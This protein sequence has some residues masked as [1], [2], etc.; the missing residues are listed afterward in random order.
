MNPLVPAALMVT[1]CLLLWSLLL[2]LGLLLLLLWT[3]GAVFPF[4]MVKPSETGFEEFCIWAL[5]FTGGSVGDMPCCICEL[6]LEAVGVAVSPVEVWEADFFVTVAGV[7][8]GEFEV[9]WSWCAET[10]VIR[11][12][13]PYSSVYPSVYVVYQGVEG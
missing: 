12:V 3:E 1:D 10:E 13:L 11:Q 4:T 7:E 6:V 5:A 8:A 9:P 2:I